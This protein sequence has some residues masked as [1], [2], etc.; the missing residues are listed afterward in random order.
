MSSKNETPAAAM[1]SSSSSSIHPRPDDDDGHVNIDQ[2]AAKRYKRDDNA[3]AEEREEE[4]DM[5]E[6]V[7]TMASL[8]AALDTAREEARAARQGEEAAREDARAAREDARAA[9][10]G[11]KAAL[12]DARAAREEARAARDSIQE[13]GRP[14]SLERAAVLIAQARAWRKEH[15]FDP[16]DPEIKALQEFKYED[17]NQVPDI[18]QVTPMAFACHLGDLEMCRIHFNHG[19]AADV[20]L[21]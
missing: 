19:A 9:R 16:C 11:G 21:H 14:S 4:D 7:E 17:D 18:L 2:P 6:D 20:R 1:S 15:G 10:E 5:Q 13:E 3:A 12:E 8:R